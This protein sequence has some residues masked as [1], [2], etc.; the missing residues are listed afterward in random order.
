M[1]GLAGDP[2]GVLGHDHRDTPS[3]HQVPHLVQSRPLQVRSGPALVSDLGQNLVALPGGPCPQGVYLLVQAVTL[4]LF[5]TRD[6]GVEDG[7]E[8][9]LL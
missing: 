2:I 9:S 5:C 7:P 6:A 8:D 4:D 3:L 1:G